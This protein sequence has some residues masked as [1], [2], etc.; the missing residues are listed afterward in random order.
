MTWKSAT[1]MFYDNKIFHKMKSEFYRDI[2][3]W[4]WILDV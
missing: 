4:E 1:G 2:V 3:E